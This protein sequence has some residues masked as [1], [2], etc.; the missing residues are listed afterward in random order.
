MKNPQVYV[1]KRLRGCLNVMTQRGVASAW[2]ACVWTITKA[3]YPTGSC[4]NCV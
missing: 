2:A 4:L 1:Y 3:F